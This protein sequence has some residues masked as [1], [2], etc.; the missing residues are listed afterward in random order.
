MTVT[1]HKSRK[2]KYSVLLAMQLLMML[3]GIVLH[4]SYVDNDMD[5]DN[6]IKMHLFDTEHGCIS[7]MLYLSAEV[8]DVWR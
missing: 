7:E 3:H 4:I 2:I 6:D 5:M 8:A 1:W